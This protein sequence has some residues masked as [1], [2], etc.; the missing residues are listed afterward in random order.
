MAPSLSRLAISAALLV[1]VTT[2]MACEVTPDQYSQAP[3]SSIGPARHVSLADHTNQEQ[4]P[5]FEPSRYR[6]ADEA[7]VS[8]FSVDVDTAAYSNIRRLLVAGQ[9]PPHDAVRIEEMVNYFDYAYDRP[10]D[11]AAPFATSLAVVPAPWSEHKLLLHV[12]I[13]GYEISSQERPRANLVLL[14]DV[15]GS[16]SWG[17]SGSMP[18]Q[19]RLDLVKQSFRLMLNQL[20]DRD[21]VAIVTYAGRSAVALEPTPASNRSKILGVLDN[22]QSGG[23]TGGAAGI[24]TAYEL[25]QQEFDTDAINRVI[26]ATDGD[27]NVGISDPKALERMIAT[28]RKTGIYLSVLTIGQGNLNDR[29]AQAL[30]Q[31]G[32][33]TAAHIDSLMEARKVLDDELASTLFPIADDVKIQIEFNP[34]RIEAYRLIGYETRMLRREDFANDR[35]DAGEIG[36]GHTVTA[37]YEIVPTGGRP[38]RTEPL[39]Y[40]PN[41]PPRPIVGGQPDTLSGEYAY[42]KIRYKKPGERSSQ[43]ISRAVRDADRFGSLEAATTDVNFA[44]AVAAFGLRLREDPELELVTY[45]NIASMAQPARGEDPYGYRAEFIR[46]V[47]AAETLTET[48]ISGR[49]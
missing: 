2:L 7:P 23:S 35:V 25:A 21:S 3:N 39:R 13:K 45:A 1:G 18:D 30:A 12:G 32:N 20:D 33:G 37:L 10:Q 29:I 14:L 5:N 11:P 48:Q 16:M 15:S 41:T 26:L 4:Y 31:T 9:L 28:K 6:R 24:A 22:L 49:R 27:F 43:L 44:V 17:V 19:S 38:W 47:R 8:I 42:L 36:S 34:A 40:R 46:L